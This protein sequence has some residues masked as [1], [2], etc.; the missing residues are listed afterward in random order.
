MFSPLTAREG[1]RTFSRRTI[2]SSILKIKALPVPPRRVESRAG[3][4]VD[5]KAFAKEVHSERRAGQ[6]AR[7]GLP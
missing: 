5:V 3:W 2:T 6:R 4:H 7:R 1:H